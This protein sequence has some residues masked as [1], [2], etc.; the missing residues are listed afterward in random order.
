MRRWWI[1][2]AV[3][4]GH[5]QRLQSYLFT[6][7]PRSTPWRTLRR[8]LP[9]PVDGGT[10]ADQACRPISPLSNL[11]QCI[12]V[13][14]RRAGPSPATL[15]SPGSSPT[16]APAPSPRWMPNALAA[17]EIVAR[18]AAARDLP[19]QPSGEV[20]M[21]KWQLEI[22]DGSFCT[23]GHALAHVMQSA[24]E[25]PAEWIT[26]RSCRFALADLCDQRAA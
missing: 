6:A 24:L 10:R 14:R 7:D 5:A 12:T 26:G 23:T 4:P 25:I 22:S 17:C 16:E 8:R 9:A 19:Y 13:R 3:S 21:P 11:L 20:I 18:T 1:S 2:G 15:T